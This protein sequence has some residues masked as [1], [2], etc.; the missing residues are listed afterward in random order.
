MVALSALIGALLAGVLGGAHCLAMCGGFVAAFSAA[1]PYGAY[2]IGEARSV[3]LVPLWALL[4]RQLAYNGGRVATYAVLGAAAGGAGGAV[5]AAADWLPLQR[6]LYAIANVFLL[7]LAVTIAWKREGIVWLQR[8]GTALF[9]KTLPAVRPL[10]GADTVLA[11]V[12]L[13]MI[14]GLVPCALTYSV[15]PIAL[16]AGGAWQGATVMLAFGIGTLP[17]LLIAGWA[18]S[19]AG[20]WLESRAVRFAAAA[21]LAGFAAVGLWRALVAS[22]ALAQGP[23]CL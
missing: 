1:P 5:L 21:L 11:R 13:G 6:T 20:R 15:L 16:F 22:A 4:R 17:S 7:A 19:R 8:I 18:V 14:W 3:P 10:L 9:A 23:Y 12:A 2:P